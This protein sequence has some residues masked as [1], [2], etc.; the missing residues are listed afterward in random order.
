MRKIVLG[1]FFGMAFLSPVFGQITV[2]NTLAPNALVQGVLLGNGVTA[3]NITYNGSAVN[4][5][6]LQT[7][8]TYFDATNTSFPIQRGVLLTTGNWYGRR[9]T[10]QCGR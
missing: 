6:Q 8:V 9:W 1:S 4:A 7:N 3:T 10:K 5:Q 2:T